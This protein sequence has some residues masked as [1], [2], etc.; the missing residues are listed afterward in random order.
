ME[1]LDNCPDLIEIF[2][3]DEKR[4]TAIA[5]KKKAAGKQWEMQKSAKNAEQA[6][7]RRTT[8]RKPQWN[9]VDE[10][11][12][13]GEIDEIGKIDEI[14]ETDETGETGETGE[15]SETDETEETGETDANHE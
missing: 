7:P 3:A 15:I 5:A 12:E 14:G 10:I 8:R 9:E 1:N 2:H 4:K 11:G 6:Q 13:T